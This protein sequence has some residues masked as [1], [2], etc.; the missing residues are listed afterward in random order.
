MGIPVVGGILLF[1]M[2]LGQFFEC[3]ALIP[4]CGL[5]IV[6][7]LTNPVQMENSLLGWVLQIVVLNTSLQIG[8]VVGLVVRNFHRAPKRSKEPGV[9]SLDET[10]S[11]SGADL[12]ESGR[13]AA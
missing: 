1:G 2:I 7:V 9:R 5:T 3:F 8:Y 12:S 10:L 4:A 13:R 6:L 11:S